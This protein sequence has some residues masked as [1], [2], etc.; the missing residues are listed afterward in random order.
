[1]L[2]VVV[3]SGSLMA[4]TYTLEKKHDHMSMDEKSGLFNTMREGMTMELMHEGHYR[5]CLD[6][7][8]VYCLSKHG[9]CDCL[10]DIMNGVHPCG[11]CIG[12]ILEGHGNPLIAKYFATAIAEKTG[13]L[14][15]IQQIISEKYDISVEE[16]V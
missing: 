7:P 9:E 3:L 16:Q 10:A 5:C 1:L 11:E 6:K 12:E 8:C 15:A 14:D 4:S 13:H 2:L